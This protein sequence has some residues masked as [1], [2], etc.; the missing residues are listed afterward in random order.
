[1]TTRRAFIGAI[2]GGFLVIP[3]AAEGQ[4]AG[5]VAKIGILW[6]GTPATTSQAFEVFLQELRALGHVE[7]IP[8]FQRIVD[9]AIKP[10]IERADAPNITF[11]NAGGSRHRGP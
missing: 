7:G 6:S 4:Q 3:L 11:V 8:D 9:F 1:M 2:V 10:P 5:K